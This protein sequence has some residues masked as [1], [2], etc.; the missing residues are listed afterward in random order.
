MV[1]EWTCRCQLRGSAAG[2]ASGPMTAIGASLGGGVAAATSAAPSDT[3]EGRLAAGRRFEARGGPEA[4]ESR[5]WYARLRAGL[6]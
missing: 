2:A 4:G 6:V 5:N 3:R 1:R